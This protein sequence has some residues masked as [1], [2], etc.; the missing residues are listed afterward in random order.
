MGR[1]HLTPSQVDTLRLA[2]WA[3]V[4]VITGSLSVGKT[5]LINSILKILCAKGV[6]VALCAP[7]SR[8][9]KRL[10]ESTELEART[11]HRPLESD[12]RTGGF[13]RGERHPLGCDLLVVDKASMVDVPLMR[14]QNRALPDRAA[15]LLVGEVDQLP[16]VGPGQ[17]LADVIGSGTL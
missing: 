9:V 1:E 17:M 4:L 11:I 14:A 6:E 12:P 5:T 13:K 16:S 3:K 7:T 8:T 15:L 2:V 10:T